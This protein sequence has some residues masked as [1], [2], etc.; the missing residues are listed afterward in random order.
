M[1]SDNSQASTF[2]LGSTLG[3]FILRLWLGF[4]ALI[5]GVEK[6]SGT[7]STSSAIEI[8]GKVNDYGLT[9]EGSSKL[10]GMEFYNGVPAPLMDKFRGEPLISESMLGLFDSCLGPALVV[11]GITLLLG[12][13]S[14]FSLFI[15]GLIYV[16]LTFGLI[17]IGQNSGIAW[18]GIH[19]LLVVYMLMNSK[20]NRLEITGKW[21]L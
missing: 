16:S 21:S 4:R 11:T 2:D 19:T 9:T 12:I 20:H 7:M 3:V 18:L 13:A 5:A 10:Y 14:R 17:L 6:Y 8:D 1:S 15:M